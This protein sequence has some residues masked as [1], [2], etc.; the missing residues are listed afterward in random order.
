MSELKSNKISPALGTT[1]TLGDSGD[2]I[3][4][5]SGATI[6]NS[7]T[8][9]GFGGGNYKNGHVSFNMTNATGT[10]IVT[11]VGFQPTHLLINA[12]INGSSKAAWS[13][14]G[15]NTRSVVSYGSSTNYYY[16][17][18]FQ[19]RTDAGTMQIID[20]TSLDS[21]GFTLSN[22]KTGSPTGTAEMFWMAL[23]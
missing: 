21:D 22:S 11:G 2:T 20:L 4:I 3:T 13:M 15:D 9:N 17:N 10:I 12:V 6:T 18:G 7:G 1:V 5:P 8:A 16:N 19:L 23:G 14:M